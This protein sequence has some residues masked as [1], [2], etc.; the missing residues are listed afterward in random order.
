MPEAA[1]FVRR[2]QRGEKVK[3]LVEEM[4]ALAWVNGVEYAVV[5]LATGDR[6]VVSGG[7]GGIE[8]LL[9][10][11]ETEVF[12]TLEGSQVQIKRVYFHTHPRV[13]GPSEGDLKVLRILRQ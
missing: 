6:V 10:Q 2:I 9:N 13:T 8:F 7:Q 5:R 3:V 1:A 12:M 11:E 4:K